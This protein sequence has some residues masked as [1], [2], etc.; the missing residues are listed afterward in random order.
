MG[1]YCQVPLG[2]KPSPT[3]FS[4]K[5]FAKLVRRRGGPFV[6][7]AFLTRRSCTILLDGEPLMHTPEA[8]AAMREWGLAALPQ[9]PPYSPDLNPQEN[10]WPWVEKQLRKKEHKSDTFAK[11]KQKLLR[12]ATGYPNASGLVASMGKRMAM[13]IAKNGAAIKK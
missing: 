1:G 4:S 5:D 13:C 9:W 6:K 2:N 11:F 12:I 10:V 3:P 7:K 8:K